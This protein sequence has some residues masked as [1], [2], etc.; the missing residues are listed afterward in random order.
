MKLFKYLHSDRTDVLKNG[1]IR[2][3]NQLGLNDPFDLK[4]YTPSI[5]QL[6]DKQLREFLTLGV[7][8]PPSLIYLYLELSGKTRDH[9][10]F[11]FAKDLPKHQTAGM[12]EGI[13][14]LI[15]EALEEHSKAI[16]NTFNETIGVLCL[17]DKI[18][19]LLMWS[20]YADSH[21][22]FAIEFDSNNNFFNR[23]LNE[24]DY[25]G[26]LQKVI[27]SENRSN[28][29]LSASINFSALLTKGIE[30][31]YESE[32]RKMDRLKNA[33]TIYGVGATAVHLFEFPKAAIIKIIFGSKLSDSKKSEIRQILNSTPEFSDVICLQANI[34][35]SKYELTFEVAP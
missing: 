16:E 22:G 34:H 11:S 7:V 9:S 15:N 24:K 31:N 1:S 26:F 5:S 2:F 14:I 19:N 4:P 17:T 30:W 21:K 13:E 32:W 35:K 29:I 10:V 3:S 18:D 8:L 23:S 20:H 33:T 6:T 12:L 25:F 27:Y 28:F